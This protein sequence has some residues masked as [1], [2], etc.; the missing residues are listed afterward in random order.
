M[1]NPSEET[2]VLAHPTC[3]ELDPSEYNAYLDWQAEQADTISLE[4]ALELIDSADYLWY[5]V[6]NLQGHETARIGF[7]VETPDCGWFGT[8]FFR[9]EAGR[10][11]KE[12]SHNG[13]TAV[14]VKAT[15]SI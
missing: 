14:L 13:L 7:H 10:F 11:R 9:T 5:S 8:T 1:S 12:M 6:R 3:A 15:D 2:N 4:Q